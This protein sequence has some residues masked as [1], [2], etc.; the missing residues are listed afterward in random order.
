MVDDSIGITNYKKE[1]LEELFKSSCQYSIPYIQR[2]FSW[3]KE[4]WE[5][6]FNDLIESIE[7]GRG[8]FFG[9]MTFQKPLD[10]KIEI[11]EG[12]QRLT[13]VTILISVIRDYLIE[14]EKDAW[15]DLDSNYI[16]NIDPLSEDSTS[17]NF[18]LELS[19]TN[20]LFFVDNIQEKGKLKEKI[21][22]MDSELRINPSNKLI[23]ECYKF[24]SQ[25]LKEKMI[26]LE[27]SQKKEYLIKVVRVLLRNFIIISAEVTDSISAYNIFQTLNDRGLDLTLADLLKTY[28]FKIVGTDWPLAKNRW[29]EIRE[30]MGNLDINTFLRHYWLSSQGVIKEKDLLS[31]IG[32]KIKTK[33]QVF[34]FLANIKNEAEGYD[35]LLNPT[36][37]Y[38]EDQETIFLLEEL[39]ILITQQ[40][41]PI[42]MA[43]NKLETKEFKKLLR[44]C[45]NFTFRYLTI[46]EAENKVIERLF[47]EIAI[48]IRE[49]EINNS[50]EII[51]YLRKYYISDDVFKSIFIKK[52]V[53]KA[54]L[55]RY[56]LEKI[57][58]FIDVDKEKFSN[59]ITVEHILPKTLNKEW[60]EY[61]NKNNMDPEEFVN[62]LGNMTLLS[63]KVNRKTQNDFFIKKR[64]EFYI[65]MTKLKINEP[66][67]NIESWT[68]MDIETRQEWFARHAVNIWKI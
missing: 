26:N 21:E 52:E 7:G 5:D 2:E 43:G 48:K 55:A 51:R 33:E 27:D 31:E 50:E 28:L 23:R 42:L 40:A 34:D 6:F 9:F 59:K 4:E 25:G 46:A 38:W 54:K 14:L 44:I 22:R 32:K 18:K 16:R 13:I 30:I 19:D 66:L 37:D 20:R 11:I 63:E 3:E 29:D 24:L 17:Y 1:S 57:E 45:I 49:K 53:R 61:V 67:K 15:K 65:K 12:Q 56:I 41:M 36:K 58:N 64:D 35:A 60:E 39:R 10:N 68:S 62:R 8:H 47:S